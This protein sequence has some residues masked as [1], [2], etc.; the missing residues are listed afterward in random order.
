MSNKNSGLKLL[1]VG[2]NLGTTEISSPYQIPNL[3]KIN[4]LLHGFSLRSDGNMSYKYGNE[5]KVSQNIKIFWASLRK[6]YNKVTPILSLQNLVLIDPEHKDK[7]IEIGDDLEKLQRFHEFGF[8]QCDALITTK[9]NILLGLLQADCIP[10]I[11]YDAEQNVLALIHAG[12]RGVSLRLPEKVVE[13][14]VTKYK[15]KPEKL[16]VGI[17]PAITVNSYVRKVRE[18]PD[19]LREKWGKYI[20]PQDKDMVGLD[21]HSFVLDQLMSKGVLKQNIFVSNVDTGA[22]KCTKTGELCFFS[23]YQEKRDNGIEV[24]RFLTVVGMF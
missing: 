10:I 8:V 15:C 2:M 4:G 14:L 13:Q 19:K 23:H 5:K 24:G 7:I 16:L 9:K 20:I 11:I 12:R 6:R 1:G 3:A 21:M 22:T 18:I 17:G